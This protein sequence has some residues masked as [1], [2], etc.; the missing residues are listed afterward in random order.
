[1]RRAIGPALTLILMFASFFVGRTT[2]SLHTLPAIAATL[3]G[4]ESEFSRELDTRI[5][6]RFPIG[7]SEDQLIEYLASEKFTPEWRRRDESN[8]SVFVRDGLLCRDIV[9]VSWR[10]DASGILVDVSGAFESHCL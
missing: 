9:R 1:M 5:R 10:A 3:P 2:G 4:D 7:S 6:Q 8:A